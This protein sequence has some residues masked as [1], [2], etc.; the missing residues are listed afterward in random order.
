MTN[1][2]QQ[3]FHY[4]GGQFADLRV[5]YR[6]HV[7][8]DPTPVERP[9]IVYF[10][11]EQISMSPATAEALAMD[12]ITALYDN[13]DL[14]MEAAGRLNTMSMTVLQDPREALEAAMMEAGADL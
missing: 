14:S 5:T 2:E 10:C 8:G 6:K 7:H 13:G 9:Y 3:A 4:R 11:T 12:L 1:I